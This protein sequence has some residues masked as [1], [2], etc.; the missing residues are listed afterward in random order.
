[1]YSLFTESKLY[2][3]IRGTRSRSSL[4][5]SKNGRVKSKSWPCSNGSNLSDHQFFELYT[6]KGV[7]SVHRETIVS[8]VIESL[9]VKRLRSL[10]NIRRRR[11]RSSGQRVG[12]GTPC[13]L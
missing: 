2:K 12:P 11:W 7:S 9:R 1:M 5:C 8:P 10:R 13:F 6:G 3:A 4:N